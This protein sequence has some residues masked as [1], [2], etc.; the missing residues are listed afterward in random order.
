MMAALSRERFCNI[1]GDAMEVMVL[2]YLGPAVSNQC[3]S[4]QCSVIA[5]MKRCAAALNKVETHN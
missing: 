3:T 2:S 5:R 4:Q 1:A